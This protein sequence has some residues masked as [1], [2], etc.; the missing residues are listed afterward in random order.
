MTLESAIELMANSPG[1]QIYIPKLSSD[2][3]KMVV[4]E[5]SHL[6]IKELSNKFNCSERT[7]YRIMNEKT[8]SSS[9]L[10]IL[11]QLE[12]EGQQKFIK[13]A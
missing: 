10:T 1:M 8:Q 13:T 11:D 9:Q 4:M 6:S 5:N 12:E 3:L 2:L 7:I